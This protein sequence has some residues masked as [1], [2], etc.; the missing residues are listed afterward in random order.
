MVD[1]IMLE[2]VS[3]A[4]PSDSSSNTDIKIFTSTTDTTSIFD[5]DNLEIFLISLQVL[6]ILLCFMTAIFRFC[7]N[8]HIGK[9]NSV[10]VRLSAPFV[11]KMVL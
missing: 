3:F 8:S 9:Y 6:Q 11:I 2:S 10:K 1:L 7:Y 4:K 5:R